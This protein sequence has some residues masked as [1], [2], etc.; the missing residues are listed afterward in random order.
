MH[1]DTVAPSS[2]LEWWAIGIVAVMS[3]ALAVATVVI[4][5]AA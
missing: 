1:G 2:S 5:L 4:V 3:L